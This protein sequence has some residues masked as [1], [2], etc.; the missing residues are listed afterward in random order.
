[1]PN[2]IVLGG[3]A[4]GRWLGLKDRALMNGIDALIKET[5]ERSPVLFHHVWIQWEVCDVEKSPHLTLLESWTQ[6]SSLQ[7][8]WDNFVFYKTP[9]YSILL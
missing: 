1:M 4:F 7:N 3:G 6:T 8:C 2:V 5:L 9:S